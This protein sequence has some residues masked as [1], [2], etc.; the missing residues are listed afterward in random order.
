MRPVV[1]YRIILIGEDDDMTTPALSDWL[2]TQQ[3]ADDLGVKRRNVQDLITRKRLS[4]QRVGRDWL[5]RRSDLDAVRNLRRGWVKGRP[6]K[7]DE[8]S[9]SN[10]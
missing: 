1:Q 7:K 2:T 9:P 5:I 6:R 10:G 8:N 3:A 4:A